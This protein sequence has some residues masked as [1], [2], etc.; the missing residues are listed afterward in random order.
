MVAIFLHSKVYSNG[1]IQPICFHKMDSIQYV[2][3]SLQESLRDL[4]L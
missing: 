3:N 4:Y 2:L 1:C